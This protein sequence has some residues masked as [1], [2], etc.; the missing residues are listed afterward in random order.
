MCARR[1]IYS[2]EPSGEFV[3]IAVV[4]FVYVG[5]RTMHLAQGAIGAYFDYYNANN[6]PELSLVRDVTIGEGEAVPPGTIFTKTWRVK[7]SG[8]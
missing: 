7:N 2:Q 5:L 1:C 8:E 6:L 3:D 4:F